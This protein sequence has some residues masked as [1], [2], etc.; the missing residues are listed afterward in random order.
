MR[1]IREGIP[2]GRKVQDESCHRSLSGKGGCTH[3]RLRFEAGTIDFHGP[4]FRID[5]PIRVERRWR[6][7]LPSCPGE[8][9][10]YRSESATR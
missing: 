2:H 3:P 1:L 7:T 5:Q 9:E 6:A 4:C 10:F 8:P